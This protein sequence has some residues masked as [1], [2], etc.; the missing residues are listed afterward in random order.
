MIL[1]FENAGTCLIVREYLDRSRNTVRRELMERFRTLVEPEALCENKEDQSPCENGEDQPSIGTI[2]QSEQQ[3][4]DEEEA[5]E[6][7]E[8]DV[9]AV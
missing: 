9:A 7:N 5:D 8:A 3:G 6:S 2:T 1:Q 4:N